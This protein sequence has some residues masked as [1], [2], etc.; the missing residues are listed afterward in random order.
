MKIILVLFYLMVFEPEVTDAADGALMMAVGFATFE[1]VCFL[2]GNGA[3]S[4][5]H[6]FTREG[7]NI[8]CIKR[9]VT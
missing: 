5:L 2:V 8:C 7:R 4:I 6:L 1:N 9:A 3:G